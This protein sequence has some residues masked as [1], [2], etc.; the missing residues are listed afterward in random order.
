LIWGKVRVKLCRG[1]WGYHGILCTNYTNI[2]VCKSVLLS[3]K[4]GGVW[5]T[6]IVLPPI[7]KG[8]QLQNDVAVV[9]TAK[10]PVDKKI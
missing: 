7:P 1:G 9:A 8:L 5:Q 10:S 4:V 2:Q 6:Y 3:G